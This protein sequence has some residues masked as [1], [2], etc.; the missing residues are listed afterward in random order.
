MIYAIGRPLNI[1][2]DQHTS[3]DFS[4][5]TTSPAVSYALSTAV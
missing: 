5:D 2:A 3:T 1:A 4:T